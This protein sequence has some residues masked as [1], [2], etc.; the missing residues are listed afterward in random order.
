MQPQ[1]FSREGSFACQPRKFSLLKVVLYMVMY[2][3]YMSKQFLLSADVHASVCMCM[4]VF[5]VSMEDWYA[6]CQ[7][8]KRWSS[9]CA[10]AC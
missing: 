5:A 8:R 1:N 4:C 3:K 7:Y 10:M 6:I 9:L 2:L